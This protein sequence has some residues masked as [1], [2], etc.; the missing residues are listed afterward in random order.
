LRGASVATGDP[1]WRIPT[2]GAKENVAKLETETNRFTGCC[3]VF[4]PTEKVTV[5]GKVLPLAPETM[6]TPSPA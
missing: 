1:F 4:G 3:V 6:V 5:A 2:P